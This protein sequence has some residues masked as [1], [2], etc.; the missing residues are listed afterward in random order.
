[1][2]RTTRH[3]FRLLA[4]VVIVFI[5]YG[6]I[7]FMVVDKISPLDALLR[8]FLLFSTLGFSE[9]TTQTVGGKWLTILLILVGISVIAYS[10]S[11]FISAVV[12]GEISGRWKKKMIDKKLKILKNHIILCGFGRL[13]RQI[14]LEMRSEDVPIVVIDREDYSAE[15]DKLDY[16]FIHGDSSAKDETLERANIKHARAVIIAMGSDSEMLATAVTARAL[17]ENITIVARANSRQAAER[18]YRVG[19]NKVALPAQIGGFHMAAMALRPSVVELL[20]LLLDSTNGTLQIE[21]YPIPNNS[22]LI[23][24]RVHDHFL[25]HRHNVS[26][27]AVK[28]KDRSDYIR[29]T[30]DTILEDRDKLIIMGTKTQLNNFIHNKG[31]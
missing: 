12:E 2:H 28:R 19:V 29:P 18:L 4:L 1:M 16:L 10:A 8:I 27:L 23:G 26:V 30:Q 15:C 9:A 13:G 6:T 25:P 7:G 22:V 5:L 21:E 24:K 31:E 20:D 14:A 11:T 3:N 17:E